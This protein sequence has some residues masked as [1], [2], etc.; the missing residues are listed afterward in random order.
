MAYTALLVYTA[1]LFVRPQEWLV[2]MRGFPVLDVVVGV[3]VVAW[4]AGAAARRWRP[5]DAPQNWLMLGLLVAVVMSHVRHTYFAATIAS[6]QSFGKVVLLYLLVA[7]LISSV[8]RARVL[9][10][11]MIAGCLVMSAHGIVQAHTGV[12][13][14]GSLPVVRGGVVRVRGFGIFHDPND[15]SLM[16][17][18]ILP[19]L[20]S[21]VLRRGQAPP[22]RAL[23]LA[24]IAPILYCIYLTNSR[25]G[26]LALGVMAL[27]YALV[28]FR[29]KKVAVAV[30]VVAVVGLVALGPSRIR[31]ISAEEGAAH[32]RIIAWGQ[33]NRMLKRWPVFG[34]GKGRFTEFS[35][36]GLVAH[37]SFVHCWAELGLFGY[38][39]WLGL[40]MATL[41]DG[42]ALTK[43]ETEE[44]DEVA[45]LRRMGGALVPALVG[46]LSAAFFLSRTYLLPL[47]I[48]FSLAA[49]LRTI[50]ERDGRELAG[51]FHLSD[52]K[53]V[54][55]AELASIPA[56]YLL[57]RLIG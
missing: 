55:A 8:R 42:W 23:S 9:I 33:G 6:F 22:V 7:S 51:A 49:A 11:V 14:G 2:W 12:G 3:A 27:V 45:Q 25:G 16:L 32:G 47:Y 34:A 21:A 38:F 15:L 35:G 1:I 46:F 28:N 39:F 13:F 17:V 44:D 5:N 10:L 30:A 36:T 57:I 50:H 19:F 37:N 31:N 40:V 4:V 53:Y 26:W 24:A 54:L 18:T 41:K 43:G 29:S 20:F 56:L 48:M 52:S